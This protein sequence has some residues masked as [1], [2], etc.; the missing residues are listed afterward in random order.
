MRGSV[1]SVARH[2]R[3]RTSALKTKL[4]AATTCHMVAAGGELHDVL[5]TQRLCE[6]WLFDFC[7]TQQQSLHS[8]SD[9]D[10]SLLPG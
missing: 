1:S 10:A 8:T 3:I 4:G 6:H 5:Y 2:K 7:H 9:S